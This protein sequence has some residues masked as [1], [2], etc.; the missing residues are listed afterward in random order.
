MKWY[1][2]CLYLC[3][4][5]AA[6]AEIRHGA[7]KN[8]ATTLSLAQIHNHDIVL[9]GRVRAYLMNIFVLQFSV[10]GVILA[11]SGAIWWW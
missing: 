9:L 6:V 3:H 8:I 4:D 5:A 10:A 2:I 7:K 11:H 1:F